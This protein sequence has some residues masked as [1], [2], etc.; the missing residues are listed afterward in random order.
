M[1]YVFLK[2]LY[3]IANENKLTIFRVKLVF[4][5]S[6][7]IFHNILWQILKVCSQRKSLYRLLKFDS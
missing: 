7:D 6:K 1:E 5:L 2:G 4:I 3:K